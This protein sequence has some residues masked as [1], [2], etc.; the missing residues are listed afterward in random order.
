MDRS[1]ERWARFASATAAF[2]LFATVGVT[3]YEGDAEFRGVARRTLATVVRHEARGSS[4][5]ARLVHPVVRF[6]DDE[7]QP[8]VAVVES[9][10]KSPLFRQGEDVVVL[11]DPEHPGRVRL[12]S[13]LGRYALPVLFLLAGLVAFLVCLRPAGARAVPREPVSAQPA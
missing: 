2:M 7:G 8:V 5:T 13:T 6:E 1:H 11:Y 4:A 9:G 3:V 10:M 12:D